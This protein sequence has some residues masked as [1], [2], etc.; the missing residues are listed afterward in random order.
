MKNMI[1]GLAASRYDVVLFSDSD[2]QVSPNYLREIVACIEDPTAGLVFS[3]HAYEGS[4]NWAAALQAISTNELVLRIA[5]MCL[6]EKFDG[7]VGSA[8]LTR[9]EVIRRIGGLEQFGRQMVDD[10]PLAR[11]IRKLG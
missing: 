3:A 1:V 7:A 11:R 4:S 2:V 6:N 10:V 5:P 8:M 9:K